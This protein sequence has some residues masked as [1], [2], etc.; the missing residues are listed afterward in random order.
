MVTEKV[1]EK[2]N[3]LC[4]YQ[5]RQINISKNHK[6]NLLPICYRLISHNKAFYKT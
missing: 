4:G 3:R 5:R 2:G 6:K 1:T